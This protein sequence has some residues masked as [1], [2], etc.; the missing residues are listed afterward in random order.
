MLNC[1]WG[2]CSS[3]V[4]NFN[5]HKSPLT[6]TIA[7]QFRH[8]KTPISV[9]LFYCVVAH[10]VHCL[11]DSR[12]CSLFVRSVFVWMAQCWLPPLTGL[13]EGQA[14][15][16][17]ITYKKYLE[18]IVF[19]STYRKKIFICINNVYTRCTHDCMR[20]PRFFYFYLNIL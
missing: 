4:H 10:V 15:K 9:F 2:C 14:G 5:Y 12:E 11:F 19:P 1:E 7:L 8:N 20:D 16:K 17:T 6:F 18:S 13:H 3:F